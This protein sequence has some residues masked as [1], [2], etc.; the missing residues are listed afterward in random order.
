VLFRS[1]FT[2]RA[3]EVKTL[4]WPTLAPGS[5]RIESAIAVGSQVTPERDPL[6]AKVI[7][8]GATRHQAI[9]TLDRVLAETEIEP[10]PTNLA[11]LRQVLASESFRA[12]QYDES[13]LEQL[14]IEQQEP[15]ADVMH[16]S[17]V[18]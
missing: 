18:L 7:A 16:D 1:G 3:G 2:P 6:L 9:L 15:G 10:L 12:G 13:F 5:L 4:R 11:F 14:L 17:A 8:F